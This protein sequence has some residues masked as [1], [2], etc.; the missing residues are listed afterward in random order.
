M[1]KNEKIF[2]IIHTIRLL[3][4]RQSRRGKVYQGIQEE[5]RHLC[6]GSS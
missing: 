5:Q 6:K 2:N 1:Q 4:I 3:P